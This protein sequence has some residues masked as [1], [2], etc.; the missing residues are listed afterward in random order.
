MPVEDQ[1][2][3]EPYDMAADLAVVRRLREMG[4]FQVEQ[5][6]LDDDH[7]VSGILDD[8]GDDFDDDPLLMILPSILQIMSEMT[9]IK[10]FFGSHIQSH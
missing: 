1:P 8:E 9:F 3:M 5:I 4:F 6:D 7:E 10:I 2:V